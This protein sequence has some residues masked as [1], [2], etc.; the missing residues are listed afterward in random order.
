MPD[1]P[2]ATRPGRLAPPPASTSG[3]PG[4]EFARLVEIMRLLRSPEGCPWDREQS[5]ESLRPF[6]LE[7]A[8]EVVDAIERGDLDGLRGEIGDLVFEGVFLAQ[9][10]SEGGTFSVADALR[11]VNEKLV[12][13]HPHVFVQAGVAP[14]SSGRIGTAGQV[15]EQ[16]EAIKARERAS[17]GASHAGALDGIP[18]SMPA[19]LAAHEMGARAAAV[20]FDWTTASDVVGKIEEEVA[21]VRHALAEGNTARVAEEIGDLFFSLANLARKLGVEPEAALRAANRKFGARFRRMEQLAELEGRT[22]KEISL[23]D[24]EALW[25]RV[26]G[27]TEGLP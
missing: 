3:A 13:R 16:W 25:Q 10:C 2:P 23:A 4:E 17:A 1:Q 14:G 7:E 15:L 11:A 6:V 9:L 18:R 5:L 24:L 21:E 22:L 26:K 8:H 20:G 12:R 27:E 19:L